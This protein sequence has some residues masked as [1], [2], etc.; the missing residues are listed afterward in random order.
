MGE[1]MSD[2]IMDFDDEGNIISHPVR[3][4]PGCEEPFCDFF[5]DVMEGGFSPDFL[6]DVYDELRIECRMHKQAEEYADRV[7]SGIQ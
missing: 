6:S 5:M 7:K 4:C 1:R 3:R 2:I